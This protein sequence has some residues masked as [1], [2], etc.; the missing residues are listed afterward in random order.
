MKEK[1]KE[2]ADKTKNIM[3]YDRRNSPRELPGGVEK[4]NPEVYINQVFH[5]FLQLKE[6]SNIR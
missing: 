6:L 4:G 2:L 1:E 3:N 5:F